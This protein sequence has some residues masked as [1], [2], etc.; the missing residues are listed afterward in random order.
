MEA[1]RV[2]DGNEPRFDIDIERGKQGEMF[3][4][5]IIEAL[6]GGGHRVEIKRDDRS[7]E[8]GNIYVE[9]MCRKRGRFEWSGIATTEAQIW[10]YVLEQGHLAVAISTERLKDLART[11]IQR[12]RVAE[13]RDGSH[14]T[15]GAIVPIRD[16]IQAGTRAVKAGLY[17]KYS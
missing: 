9:Y 6:K 17:G 3:V 14:P 11:A 4:H 8:T 13:E 7:Q 1:D 2:P 5:G 12:G 10:V 15:K 16:L